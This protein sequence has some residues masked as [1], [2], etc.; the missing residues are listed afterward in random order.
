M[1]KLTIEELAVF[2]KR[3]GFVYQNS[4]IYGGMSGF[5]DYGPLGAELKNNIK[6]EWWKTH[7]RQRA[8]V[9][10]IDG[11]IITNPK[12]WQASGHVENFTDLMLN[13]VKCGHK[14]RADLLIE[15]K[16]NISADGLDAKQIGELIKK[17]K[18]KCTRCGNDVKAPQPFNLMFETNVGPS[19]TKNIAYLRPET[20]QVIFTNFKLVQENA[21]MKLPFGIAQIGRAFRNEISPRDFLFRCR[22]FEQMEIEYFV[23]PY[24]VNDCPYIKEVSSHSFNVLTSEMQ[25][26][27]QK[28]KKMKVSEM[29]TKKL[30]LPWHAYWLAHEHKWLTSLGVKAENLRIRQ[31]VDT[32]KSHYATDTWDLEYNF[33]FGWKELEGVSNRGDFDLKQHMKTSG[34]DLSYYDEEEKAK[35][36]PHVVAEPSLGVDRT[37]LVFLFDAY[38][39]DKKRENVV[40]KLHPKLAPI[41]IAIFPLLS[42]KK[43]L[44]KMAKDVYDDLKKEFNCFLDEKGSI[45]K[46]YARMDEAGTP[47]ALTLDFDSLKKKDVTIRDRDSTRQVRI[48]IKGLKDEIRKRL[49]CCC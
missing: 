44:V 5:F 19:E 3:K 34:K 33:P 29:L 22:E 35:I 48:K 36:I 6:A 23:H 9:V 30:I 20:A 17:H 1:D 4:E 11:S 7:V 40:L 32:E 49:L 42:N 8:D 26:K 13:C 45:G 14:E 47:I 2:C 21:R 46:R 39:Y 37:F 25:H 43:E 31:H 12:V 24:K 16:L 18:I 27:K 10:G 28:P 41:K 38:E 15:S